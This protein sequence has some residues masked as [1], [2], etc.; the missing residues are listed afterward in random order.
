[1]GYRRDRETGLWLPRNVCNAGFCIAGFP[2]QGNPPAP[3]P[4]PT[5]ASI[6]TGNEGTFASG[7]SFSGPPGN[8]SVNFN[9]AQLTVAVNDFLVA[10][11]LVFHVG[12]G[13]D[14]TNFSGGLPAGWAMAR[15]DPNP[16]TG[17]SH[18]PIYCGIAT[19]LVTVVDAGQPTYNFSL[20]GA[21]AT[22][23]QGVVNIAVVRGSAGIEH[24]A[25][26]ARN[27]AS[28]GKISAPSVATDAG[29]ELVLVAGLF[30]TGS[31]STISS[32]NALTPATAGN[33]QADAIFR[34]LSTGPNSLA[35]GLTCVN[36]GDA[37][38]AYQVSMVGS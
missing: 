11:I 30:G 16:G 37:F 36:T 22:H 2:I 18:G 32:D 6:V 34:Q 5:P 3:P 29:N 33:V 10:F 24:V 38:T 7:D 17:S 26:F 8:I 21:G 13:V 27:N 20:S 25:T 9:V 31:G 4:P 1:L 23:N 19:H 15:N 28:D 12:G 14:I 35:Q